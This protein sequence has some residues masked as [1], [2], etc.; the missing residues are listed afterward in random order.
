MKKPVLLV[1]ATLFGLFSA[2][3]VWATLTAL[4]RLVSEPGLVAGRA[5]IAIA[6][7]WMAFW[8]WPLARRASRREGESP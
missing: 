5:A 2:F 7:G 4:N 1:I 6:S 8:A 3:H